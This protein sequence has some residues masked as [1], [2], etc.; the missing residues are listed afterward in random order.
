VQEEDSGL[1][2][3]T[4]SQ[5][6][7]PGEDFM[8]FGL[9]G[10]TVFPASLARRGTKAYRTYFQQIRRRRNHPVVGDPT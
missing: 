4:F 8:L 1:S 9:I 7:H 10:I 3:K 6:I 2:A 5:L